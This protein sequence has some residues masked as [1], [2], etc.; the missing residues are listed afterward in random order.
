M[1][2]DLPFGS[3]AFATPGPQALTAA[4][5]RGE[6][7]TLSP[8]PIPRPAK[9]PWFTSRAY[10]AARRRGA[11][12]YRGLHVLYS[13]DASFGVDESDRAGTVSILHPE[14][15]LLLGRTVGDPDLYAYPF[16]IGGGY[17]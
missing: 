6:I 8:T 5:R 7:S 11:A 4:A 15:E 12:L 2:K 1:K 13:H 3:P 17:L 9:K 14:R 10:L 16:A